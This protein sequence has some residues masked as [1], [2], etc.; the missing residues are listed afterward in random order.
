MCGGEVDDGVV[1]CWVV[2][3]D[4]GF[5]VEV[6]LCEG[7]GDGCVGVVGGIVGSEVVVVGIECVV[8]DGVLVVGFGDVELVVYVD[9]GEDDCFGVV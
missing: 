5:V 7:G 1:G 6:Y 8:E 3:G 2:D 4:V 9:F